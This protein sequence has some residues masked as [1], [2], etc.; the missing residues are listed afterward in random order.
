VLKLRPPLKWHDFDGHMSTVAIT[1][2]GCPG[3]WLVAGGGPLPAVDAAVP[4]Q[5]ALQA[6]AAASE[7][8]G[9]T[10]AGTGAGAACGG[11]GS[12]C[13][14]WTVPTAGGMMHLILPSRHGLGF[15]A[16]A[17]GL[18]LLEPKWL[19]VVITIMMKP[20]FDGP[21]PHPTP[22]HPHPTPPHRNPRYNCDNTAAILLQFNIPNSNFGSGV[23]G[24]G[25][26]QGEA[27]DGQGSLRGRRCGCGRG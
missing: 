26:G 7:P 9:R 13:G 25:V 23:C 22:P 19:R 5:A 16:V 20:I 14:S 24:E 4:L 3:W 27:A 11:A 8:T 2:G 6:V 21:P 1:A 10:G 15:S 17:A 18:I 12:G